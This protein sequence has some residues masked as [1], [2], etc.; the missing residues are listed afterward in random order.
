MKALVTGGAGFI[1]SAFVKL[2]CDR[3]HEIVVV[4]KLTYAGNLDRL[5]G[6]VYKFYQVDIQDCERVVAEEKPNVIINFAAE[7]HVDRSIKDCSIFLQTNYV[8]VSILLN[9][10]IKYNIRYIH[11]STDEV[12]GDRGG[13]FKEW[14]TLNPSNP[15]S[16]SKAA[17][18]L[19]IG[20]YERTFGFKSTIIRPS[21]NF[22]PYQHPEKFIPLT[23]LRAF[24]NQPSLV[25]GDGTN[26]REW[27]YVED[28]VKGIYLVMEKEKAGIYNIGSGFEVDNLFVVKTV[29]E[30]LRKEQKVTF[31][32]DRPGHDKRY[33]VDSSKMYE[34]GWKPEVTFNDG[35]NRIINWY[36]T[37]NKNKC[38]T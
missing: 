13:P 24:R 21:N 18:D 5:I 3:G 25:Y 17:A 33:L 22:G 30:T 38:Y 37:L 31:I 7:S 28:C 20:S 19:L 8:G 10:C 35:I 26:K 1:G 14:D 23:I 12:Y 16:A 15:Y 29:W 6:F 9:I 4:D 11:I 32:K 36:L 2:L 34:L 27:L